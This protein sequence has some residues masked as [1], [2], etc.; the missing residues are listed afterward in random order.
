MGQWKVTDT[1]SL[2]PPFTAEGKDI[3]LTQLRVICLCLGFQEKGKVL[4]FLDFN[5]HTPIIMYFSHKRGSSDTTQK[6]ENNK[7][8]ISSNHLT[9]KPTDLVVSEQIT[10]SADPSGSQDRICVKL[11]QGP[12]VVSTFR[13]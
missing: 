10:T 13:S 6:K 4:G 12:F 9:T 5:P 11:P 2:S 3:P 1:N 7:K 8:K